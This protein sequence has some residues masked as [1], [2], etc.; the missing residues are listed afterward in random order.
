[1]TAVELAVQDVHGIAVAAA[2]R[3]DRIELCSALA[4][5]GLTPSLALIEAA[6]AG[7]VPVHVLIRPRAGDFSYTPEER[8]VIVRD[9]R[10]AVEAGVAGI[11]A[12]GVADAQPDL[13]LVDELRQAIGGAELTFHRAFDTVP[14][15]IG[16]LVALTAHGVA[17]VLTSGGADRAE[18]A[19]SQLAQL[20]DRAAGAIQVMAGGGLTAE[21]V[22]AVLDSG[23]DAVHA[24]AKSTVTG[25][26]AVA[27]GSAVDGGPTSWET[28]DQDRARDF[29][30]AVRR[31]SD[32]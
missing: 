22:Q 6:V 19:T 29:V 2:V 7:P 17:R 3:P 13:R 14:D 24:S 15:R 25:A 4:L 18:L 28:T 27:L 9:A 26:I 31:G 8:S 23:V 30:A 5:G 16:A 1:M 12:G 21:N 32:G 20:V 10:R 11:V